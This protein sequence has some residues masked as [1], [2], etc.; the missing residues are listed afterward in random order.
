MGYYDV[1]VICDGA[2]EATA[3]EYNPE[4]VDAFVNIYR[5]EKLPVAIYVLYHDH[6]DY[7]ECECV[8]YVTDHAP[9][10]TNVKKG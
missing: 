9:F 2:L 7:L 1:S 3:T 10:W 5:S 4:D 6:E 8:Q